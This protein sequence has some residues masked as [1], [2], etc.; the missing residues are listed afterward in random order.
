MFDQISDVATKPRP[1]LVSSGIF[2][3]AAALAF[4]LVAPLLSIPALPRIPERQP[5]T[6]LAVSMAPPRQEPPSRVSKPAAAAPLAT[7]RPFVAPRFVPPTTFVASEPRLVLE[8][9]PEFE[10]FAAGPTILVGVPRIESQAAPPIERRAETK[11]ASAVPQAPTRVGGSVQE[12]L[13]IYR[14]LPRFP[15]MARIANVQGTVTLEAIIGKDGIVKK[16]RVVSGPGLLVAEAMRAVGQWRY[17][18]TLLNG[19]PVE[20]ATT[21][22]INFVLGR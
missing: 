9:P 11:P 20:V 8:A 10:G 15:P 21:I 1:W 12:A 14:V 3:E 5:I 2:L 16:L 4:L 18:P 22:S 7:L 19:E 13:L 6:A 17:S